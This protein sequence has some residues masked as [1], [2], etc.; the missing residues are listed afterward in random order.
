VLVGFLFVWE[1]TRVA[2]LDLGVSFGYRSLISSALSF[3][4]LIMTAVNLAA[5]LTWDAGLG[6]GLVYGGVFL[7][8]AV[9]LGVVVG[10]GG[11]AHGRIWDQYGP[12]RALT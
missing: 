12:P 7:W 10:L 2:R 11:L 5:R 3:G 8:I 9:A 6:G 1:A 4:V